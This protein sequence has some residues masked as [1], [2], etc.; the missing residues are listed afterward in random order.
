[1][2]SL[3]VGRD[4]NF[5]QGP[6]ESPDIRGEGSGVTSAIALSMGED[7]AE[8]G[9]EPNCEPEPTLPARA[10][11]MLCVR[12]GGLIRFAGWLFDSIDC[13]TEEALSVAGVREYPG[14]ISVC[15][16]SPALKGLC[17]CGSRWRGFDMVSNADRV[18]GSL[19]FAKFVGGGEGAMVVVRNGTAVVGAEIE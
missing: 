6:G 2:Y 12:G 14:M 18:A 5:L 7:K 13:R 9:A 16:C 1:M 10:F 19:D 15:R 17:L 8:F 11:F 3:D 4:T